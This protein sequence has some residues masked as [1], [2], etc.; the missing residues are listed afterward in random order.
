VSPTIFVNRSL[1][2]LIDVAIIAASFVAAYILR[3]EGFPDGQP[4]KHMIFQIPYVTL[5]T[6]VVYFGV[7]VH[8]YVWRF[9]SL[10][11]ISGFA[12]AHGAV[13]AALVIARLI[14]PDAYMYGRVPLSVTAINFML[15]FLGTV[16]VRALRRASVE[17]QDS[18]QSRR[19]GDT[20]A[21]RR[22]LLIG[23][24]RAGHIVARELSQRKDLGMTPVGFVDD[25]PAKNEMIVGGV[26]VLGSLD[27]LPQFIERAKADLLLISVASATGQEMRRIKAFCDKTG[28]PTKIVPGI[29][30]LIDGS[31]S[32]S[33][34]RD[35]QP[36]DLLGRAPVTLDAASIAAF[37]NGRRILVTGAGGSIGS[38]MCRQVCR[39]APKALILLDQ[40]EFGLFEIDRELRDQFPGQT[41]VAAIGD[42]T[43]AGR[44]ADIFKTH[45]PDVVIHAAAHKHVPLMELNPGEAVKNNIFGTK[46]VAD[47]AAERGV[48]KFIFISTDKAVNPT[49][50]MGATKRVAERY[51]QAL[52]QKTGRDFVTVRF[53]NVLGSV[54]SVIPVFKSQIAKG[55]PVTV[56]HPE[57]KRYF[58]TIPEAS[59]LVLQAASLGG[60][61]DIFILDM[62]EP[63]SILQLAEDMIVYSGLRPYA[64]V[65][66]V[67]TGVRPGEK[68]FEQIALDNE[69]AEKTRHPKIYIGKETPLPFDDL[70]AAI[71]ALKQVTHTNCVATVRQALR[72]IVPEAAFEPRRPERLTAEEA[73]AEKVQAAQSLAGEATPR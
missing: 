33:R 19:P 9:V 67:F 8:R 36:E 1:Q 3:F 58:M 15:V 59:Q 5:F 25:D 16:G 62:G 23:A 70:A 64:D 47:L 46:N 69:R 63:V 13:A 68:L 2:Y 21:L 61:G 35:V 55:G 50:V 31:V 37:L 60:R 11:D 65:D 17:W 51:V 66:I 52:A 41:V 57:M 32:V 12:L 22:V 14:L 40:T 53:G 6:L 30:E 28:L 43:D 48:E 56:T 38:E 49:S 18:R 20:A 73:E 4:L 54:G 71:D 24:G 10:R 44:T 29:Y 42:V 39:F 26:K 27:Y 34:I 72:R 7:G 45:K